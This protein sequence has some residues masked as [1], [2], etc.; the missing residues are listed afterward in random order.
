MMIGFLAPHFHD[1]P[2]RLL[3]LIRSQAEFG[4]GVRPDRPID[5][6]PG[7]EDAHLDQLIEPFFGQQIHVGLAEAGADAR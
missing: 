6:E 1:E 2:A 3:L 7:V 5:V 4:R